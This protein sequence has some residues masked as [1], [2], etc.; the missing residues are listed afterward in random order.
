[1]NMWKHIISRRRIH[2]ILLNFLVNRGQC[3]KFDFWIKNG[4]RNLP[5]GKKLININIYNIYEAEGL[6]PFSLEPTWLYQLSTVHGTDNGWHFTFCVKLIN[7]KPK[8]STVTFYKFPDRELDSI[9]KSE[10]KGKNISLLIP[11]SDHHQPIMSSRLLLIMVLALLGAL[12]CTTSGRKLTSS[13][14]NGAPL[15]DEKTF[16]HSFPGVGVSIGGAN[17]GFGG[18]A[19]GGVGGGVGLGSGFGSGAGGGFG[20]GI[21]GLGGGGGGGGG[22]GGGSGGGLLGA[23]YGGGAGGGFGGGIPWSRLAPSI[24]NE[25]TNGEIWC[26]SKMRLFMLSF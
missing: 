3:N 14:T 10:K 4:K 20:S 18:G 16:Y 23:G 11:S 19:G 25:Q 17:G 24:I 13:Q 6:S 5:R 1:M 22:F 7:L 15:N 12:V 8:S 9:T 21:G 2:R 26:G